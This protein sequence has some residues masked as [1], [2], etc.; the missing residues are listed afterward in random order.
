MSIDA[1]QPRKDFLPQAYSVK[2]APVKPWINVFERQ[3]HRKMNHDRTLIILKQE[4]HIIGY[5]RIVHGEKLMYFST[6]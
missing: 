6:C 2:E 5:N 4:V 1:L 3:N